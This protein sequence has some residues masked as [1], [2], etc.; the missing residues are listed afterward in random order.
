MPLNRIL[1]YVA[2]ID[3]TAAF[4]ETH[5]GFRAERAPG[6][7]IV[8]YGK[9]LSILAKADYK[10]WLVQEAEQDPRLFNPKIYAEL[11]NAYLRATAKAAKLKVVG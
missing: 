3:K 10:G 6:D 8:D 9:V 5:F 11:G 7:G 2:D 4:Y 1:L